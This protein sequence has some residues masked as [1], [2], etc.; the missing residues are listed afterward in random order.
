MSAVQYPFIDVAVHK[1]VR[2]RFARGEALVLF[3]RDMDRV[4]WANGAG[5]AFFGNVS[6]YD[7]IDQGP[8]RQDV[9]FRQLKAT[10]DQLGHRGD[11]RGLVMRVSSG[12][13][14]TPIQAT[15]EMVQVRAGDTAVLFSVPLEGKL[16]LA[17]R[18]QRMLSGFDDPDTH[19]AM[20]DDTGNVVAASQSF[21]ALAITPHTARTLVDLVGSMP[22]RLLKRPIQTGRGYLPSAIG[23][24]SDEPGLYLL[25][26][27]E[28]ILGD[29]NP[30][31]DAESTVAAAPVTG[32]VAGGE[33]S[34]FAAVVEAI[35]DIEEIDEPEAD[36]DAGEPAA[37]QETDVPA[38]DGIETEPQEEP[39]IVPEP[40]DETA[41]PEAEAELALD[42][43][44]AQPEEL[45]VHLPAKRPLLPSRSRSIPPPF[46]PRLMLQPRRSSSTATPGHC[47]SSGRSMRRAG[48]AKS[49]GSSPRL[50]ARELPI[51][52]A[53]PLAMS[54]R[55]SISI[56]RARLPSF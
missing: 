14:M 13:R 26:T 11:S 30:G 18:A 29:M 3:A 52:M 34:G 23:K 9:S 27:V 38:P 25:F 43:P 7:F 16:G 54:R 24:V 47:A 2:S 42:A 28:T 35:G 37:D 33:P 46:I 32:T 48:S 8:N 4:L 45:P 44:E 19:M 51:S 31:H 36:D 22:E 1:D 10:A 50:S 20:L 41:E 53:L 56:P 15:V 55:C 6:I 17:E 40:M 12:F 49:P 5:A 39:A 21:A